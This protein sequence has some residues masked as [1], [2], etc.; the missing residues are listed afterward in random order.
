[1]ITFKQFLKEDETIT[2]SQVISECKPFLKAA[3]GEF[4][5]R[6]IKNPNR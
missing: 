1:M 6:G 2:L 5:L 3:Q 4:I